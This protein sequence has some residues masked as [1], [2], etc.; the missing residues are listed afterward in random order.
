MDAM[1]MQAMAA[2]QSRRR[3]AQ[4]ARVRAALARLDAGDYG[5]CV[6]CEEAI[7]PARLA[8]D[9]ATPACRACASGQRAD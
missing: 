8:F 3:S 2:A 4:M 7:E 9:P 5:L 1:Q 6:I